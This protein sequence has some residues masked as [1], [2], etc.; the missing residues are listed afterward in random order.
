MVFALLFQIYIY[1]W[2]NQPQISSLIFS[3]HKYRMN[4]K[5]IQRDKEITKT[6]ISGANSAT[7]IIPRSVAKEYGLDSPS[8]VIVEVEHP[9]VFSS[10]SLTW[11]GGIFIESSNVIC[12]K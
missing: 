7:L 12:T 10:E 9:K 11:K 2:S 6:W 5:S 1:P 8:H 3:Y 4:N